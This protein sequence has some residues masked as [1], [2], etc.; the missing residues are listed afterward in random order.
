MQLFLEPVDVWLFRDGRPFD[1]RSDHRAYS[2]FPPYPSVIQGVIRSH[3]LVVKNVNLMDRKAIASEVGTA[4][5]FGK[6]RMKG[7]L[8]AKSDEG[9]NSIV[10][11]FPIPAD[12]MANNEGNFRALQPKHPPSRT[13]TSSMSELPLLLWPNERPQKADFGE[14]LSEVDLLRCLTGETVRGIHSA[15]LF[16]HE[17]RIGIGIDNAK[18]TTRPEYLYEVDFVRPCNNVGMWVEVQGYDGW[19]NAGIL[20]IGGEGRG[21]SFEQISPVTWPDLPDPLPE[22]FKVYFAA[23]TFFEKGWRP[24]DWSKFFDGKVNLQTVALNRYDSLGGFDFALGKQKASR[25]YVPA[26]S[27]FYF[28]CEGEVKIKS[29]LIQNAITDF[30]AE[31]GFGQTIIAEWRE[32]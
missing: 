14:W 29:E 10:R 16:Q 30:G 28:K 6:L 24:S 5:D 25:R 3:H 27:V 17:R 11:Y 15:E 12:V 21:A 2:L 32:G 9:T 4:A 1:A 26:G 13:L 31:I 23:P 18:R 22:L 19:P 8:I 7:P 20:R